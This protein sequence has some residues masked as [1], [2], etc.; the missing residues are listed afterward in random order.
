MSGNKAFTAGGKFPSS[1]SGN[2]MLTSRSTA[3]LLAGNSQKYS[4]ENDPIVVQRLESMASEKRQD[5]C[6]DK[7]YEHLPGPG[8]NEELAQLSV[9]GTNVFNSEKAC[10]LRLIEQQNNSQRLAEKL[11]SNLSG[12]AVAVASH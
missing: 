6:R 7:L 3:S 4:L 11:N 12:S 1:K 8:T 10:A 2:L 5:S 9:V